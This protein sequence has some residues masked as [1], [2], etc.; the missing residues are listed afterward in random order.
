MSNV[1]DITNGGS[2]GDANS[3][4][5]EDWLNEATLLDD[6]KSGSGSFKHPMGKSVI[7][8][9]QEIDKDIDYSAKTHEFDTTSTAARVAASNTDVD[10]NTGAVTGHMDSATPIRADSSSNAGADGKAAA[11][12]E[13]GHVLGPIRMRSASS[14]VL[15]GAVGSSVDATLASPAVTT[16][17]DGNVHSSVVRHKS[18]NN[19]GFDVAKRV[20][21]FSEDRTNKMK[22][23][24]V[25]I[26]SKAMLLVV[27]GFVIYFAGFG[28]SLIH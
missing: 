10:T 26:I 4:E 15:G 12:I 22:R 21:Q 17:T 20:A 19:V 5:N 18:E 6:A 27:A 7:A 3:D 14:H 25:T 9:L 8:T 13:A 11:K 16:G 28:E 1:D 24:Y 2:H 23:R